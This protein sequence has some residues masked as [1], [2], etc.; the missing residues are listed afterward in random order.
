MRIFSG[1]H[2]DRP[3]KVHQAA[4]DWL[5]VDFQDEWGGHEIIGVRQIECTEQEW[6]DLVS[7][8][9]PHSGMLSTAWRWEAGRL[10]L[11]RDAS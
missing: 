1:N 7:T 2:A 8:A 11:S 6:E 5:S 3:F 10:V 4:N 9:G